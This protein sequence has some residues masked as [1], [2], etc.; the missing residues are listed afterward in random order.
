MNRYILVYLG[1]KPPATPEEGK[2]HFANYQ[3][4]LASLG[5]AAVSPMNPLK[6]TKAVSRD[7]GISDMGSGMSGY[8]I[9]EADSMDDAMQMAIA[10]PFLELGGTMEVSELIQMGD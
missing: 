1:G 5:D 9:V 10:C 2:L 4:W 8:T 7:G 6:G 3:K